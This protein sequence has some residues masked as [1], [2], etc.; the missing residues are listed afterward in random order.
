MS[1]GKILAPVFIA[2]I[3]GAAAAFAVWAQEPFLAPSLGS[4]V[5]SQLLHPQEKSAKPYAIVAGQILGAAAGFAGVFVAGAAIA[6]PFIGSHPLTSVR[7]G[8]IV[9]A[10][11]LAATGQVATGALTP[12]GGATAL[13]VA[14]GAEADDWN[15]IIRLAVGLV[16]VTALGE[17][18]RQFLLRL[19]QVTAE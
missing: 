9:V 14:L 2:I 3:L 4:S 6:P 12:A 18:A 17:V 19:H 8:A 1:L 10:G 13:V 15:G 11:L 5:F 7:V 16:I